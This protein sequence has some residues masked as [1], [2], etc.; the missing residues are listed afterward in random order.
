LLIFGFWRPQ[1]AG[2]SIA[3]IAAFLAINFPLYRFFYCKRGLWFMIRAFPWH[4]AY[5]LCCG[6]AFA[7]GL[8]RALFIK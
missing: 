4:C 1:I 2:I 8:L 7:V 3:F 6:L 5:Y